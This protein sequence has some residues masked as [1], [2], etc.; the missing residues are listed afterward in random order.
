MVTDYHICATF[1][2][3]VY[4]KLKMVSTQSIIN[5]HLNKIADMAQ[6]FK[7]EQK[8]YSQ[9]SL[10]KKQKVS[11]IVSIFAETVDDKNKESELEEVL[12]YYNYPLNA[13]DLKMSPIK[14]WVKYENVFPRLSQLSRMVHSVPATNLSSERNFNYAGLTLTDRRSNLDPEKVDKML[15][16]RSNFDLL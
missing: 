6:Q 3:P 11:H 13:E 8:V 4:R 2:T 1:L 10:N 5:D 14:F 16:I 9:D 7:I 12:R 15:F